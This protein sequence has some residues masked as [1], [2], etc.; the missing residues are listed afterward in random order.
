M[1]AMR[2]FEK[3]PIPARD[4][5]GV[6][7]VITLLVLVLL[8]LLGLSLMNASLSEKTISS[9]EVEAAR[10]FYAAEAGLQHGKKSLEA[11]TLSALLDGTDD[12]FAG[13]GKG[14]GKGAGSSATIAG[15]TYTLQVSNNIAANGFPRGTIPADPSNSDTVDGDDIIVLTSTATFRTGRQIVENVLQSQGSFPSIPG[16]VV[17][18]SNGWNDLDVGGM[19]SGFDESKTC[20][21]QAGHFHRGKTVIIEGNT[22]TG[23]P[24]TRKYDAAIDDP[25]WNDPNAVVALVEG[26][27]NDPSAVKITGDTPPK[28]LGTKSKPQI[29]VWDPT[30]TDTDSDKKASFEGYGILIM[31][32][33]V[34]LKTSFEFHG[35][36]VAY[37]GEEMAIEGGNGQVLHGAIIAANKDP[38]PSGEATEVGVLNGAKV[39]YNCAEI[40]QYVK[41]LG[42]GGAGPQQVL[43]WRPR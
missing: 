7:L 5:R 37:G 35:L 30:S 21:D 38:N 15:A 23:D 2:R 29:T 39:N 43:S 8:S 6:V 26:W 33:R 4:E 19:I 10:A 11:L 3:L 9:N 31:V 17:Q 25:F 22:V 34:N 12:I 32:G 36:I 14:K 42:G 28:K 13:K 27:M 40:E 1:K 41:P 20:K 18:V 24:N 16:A